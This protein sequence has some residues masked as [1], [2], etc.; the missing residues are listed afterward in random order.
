VIETR[1]REHL[2]DVLAQLAARGFGVR[3]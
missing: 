3:T 1:D 2:N